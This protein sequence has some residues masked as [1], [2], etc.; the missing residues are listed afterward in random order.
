VTSRIINI[1]FL[2]CLYFKCISGDTNKDTLIQQWHVSYYSSQIEISAIIFKPRNSILQKLPA[3]VMAPGFSGVKE[4]NYPFIAEYI[5]KEGFAALL[6]DYPNFGESAGIPRYEA[7]PGVQIQ[8]YREGISF[9]INL[10][11]VDKSRIGIWGGSYSGGHALVVS[12]L[13]KRVKCM[14]AITPFISG[15]YYLNTMPGT[16]RDFLIHQFD[17]DRS[18]RL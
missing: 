11:Y 9:L 14:V 16:A 12:A 15:S 17:E 4:C 7:D 13:D 6:F 5:A 18:V 10:E 8:A 3:I 2:S 1:I